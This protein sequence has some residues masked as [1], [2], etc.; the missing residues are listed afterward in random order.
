MST[1]NQPI[2]RIRLG[3]VQAAIWKNEDS[4]GRTR[5]SA[6]VE[7]IYRDGK[8]DWQSTGSFGRDELLTLSKIAD[9]ANSRIFE[10]Q[11]A[12]R[13]QTAS[14]EAAPAAKAKAKANAR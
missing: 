4:E 1:S 3:A 5:Y 2:D 11:V 12:D 10:L 13:E 6:T 8:G 7:R 9:L 14:N